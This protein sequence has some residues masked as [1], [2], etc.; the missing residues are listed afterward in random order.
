M[1]GRDL[2]IIQSRVTGACKV[3]RSDDPNRR[4]LQL[5]TGSPH[6]LKLI[7]ALEGGGYREASVHRQ[8]RAHKTRGSQSGEWF[9]ESGLGEVPPDVWEQVQ[10]WY[11]EDPDWWKRG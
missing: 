5:Q 8:M 10:A 4:L 2:Y 7:L 3:G 11:L 9:S 1:A 6:Q